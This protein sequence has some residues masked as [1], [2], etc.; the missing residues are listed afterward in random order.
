M[1]TTSA[2]RKNALR[3]IILTVLVISMLVT[4]YLVYTMFASLAQPSIAPVQDI[5]LTGGRNPLDTPVQLDDFTLSGSR[6]AVSLSDLRGK[7]ALLFFGYTHCPDVCLVT[8]AN[9]KRIKV[10]LGDDADQMNFVFISVD[11]PRDT[12]DVV[13]EY[14]AKFDPGFIGL[15]SDELTLRRIAPAYGLQFELENDDG[16]KTEDYNVI[17]TSY[18]YLIDQEG[19]MIIKYDYGADVELMI[20]DAR[21]LI[22]A[23]DEE[24]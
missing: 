12:P 15:S 6:G 21:A 20:N 19:R 16:A 5:S 2:Q 8:L 1:E 10:E 17:H 24:T 9:F 13:G 3:Y 23:A 14:V 4:G 18:A 7:V 11:S 22:G